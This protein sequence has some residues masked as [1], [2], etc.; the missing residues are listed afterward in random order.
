MDRSMTEIGSQTEM[1]GRRAW[2]W[3]WV[4]VCTVIRPCYRSRRI[5]QKKTRVNDGDSL[6]RGV[7]GR[8]G[9]HRRFRRGGSPSA[10]SRLQILGPESVQVDTAEERY[11]LPPE[12][13]LA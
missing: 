11:L 12:Q 1:E 7:V 8:I 5:P 9:V 4:R 13:R 2:L 6:F 3:G 10:S